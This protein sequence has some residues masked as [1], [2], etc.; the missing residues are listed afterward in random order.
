MAKRHICITINP[1]L[2][3]VLDAVAASEKRTRS[4]MIELIVEKHLRDNG[5]LD[6][7]NLNDSR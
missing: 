3:R 6:A 5:N 2:L 7:V 4:N 1:K